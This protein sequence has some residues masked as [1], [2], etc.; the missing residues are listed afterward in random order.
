MCVCVCCHKGYLYGPGE[1]PKEDHGPSREERKADA[2]VKWIRVP[3]SKENYDHSHL[4]AWWWQWEWQPAKKKRN[5]SLKP[6]QTTA[7][8]T[9]Q[10]SA[11]QKAE[12]TKLATI[13]E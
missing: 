2:T 9:E 5:K 10:K 12:H 11:P 4:N 1:R 13:Y 3:V 6:N 7:A 8:N